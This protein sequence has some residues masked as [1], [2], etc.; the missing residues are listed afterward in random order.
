MK[1][2]LFPIKNLLLIFIKT[3]LTNFSCV[4]LKGNKGDSGRSG[5]PGIQGLRGMPV[6]I[7]LM[8]L[9]SNF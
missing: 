8:L 1:V 9:R 7:P 6:S 5:T 3:S 2:F 4:S